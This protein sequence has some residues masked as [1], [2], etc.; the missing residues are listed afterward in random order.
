MF[1]EK[2][3]NFVSTF[4]GGKKNLSVLFDFLE[5][6]KRAIFYT[7]RITN[8]GFCIIR[9]ALVGQSKR[10]YIRVID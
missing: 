8:N 3:R 10:N 6:N 4:M 1:F 2:K 9:T 5:K 7:I